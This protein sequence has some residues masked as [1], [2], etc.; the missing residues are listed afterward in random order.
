[1]RMTSGVRDYFLDAAHYRQCPR[2]VVER[3]PLGD[4]EMDVEQLGV[5]G[6]RADG[7]SDVGRGAVAHLSDD[8]PHFR[9]QEARKPVCLIDVLGCCARGQARSDVE[10]EAE[11]Q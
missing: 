7:L 3:Q 5:G 6:K 1:M 2:A 11:G 9:Q 4:V 10:L 8:A